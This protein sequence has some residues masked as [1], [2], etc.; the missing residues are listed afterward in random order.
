MMY[1]KNGYT[2]SFYFWLDLI[3]TLTLLLDVGWISDAIFGTGSSTNSALSGA[4][5]ARAARASKIGSKA[6]RI[7]RILRLIRLIRIVKFYK[8]TE[9]LK[10]DKLNKKDINTSQLGL[11]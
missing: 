8:A 10:E 5:I 9:K 2:N 11:V 6:G 1:A 7:V 4:T 3:S